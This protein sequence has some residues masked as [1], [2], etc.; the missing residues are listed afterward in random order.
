M[1]VNATAGTALFILYAAVIGALVSG[2]FVV[3]PKST[4]AASFLV[5]AATFGVLSV[6][7]FVLKKDLS[8]FGSYLIMGAIGLFIASIV[9]IFLANDALSWIITY[10]VLAVFIGLT[11]YYTQKLK[12]WALEVSDNPE[13]ASRLAVVGSLMMYVAFLNMFLSILRIMGS[14]R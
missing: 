4:L 1:S 7:G 13:M 12:G 11:V 6:L 2:I 5:T 10:G 3:Y 9:N 8:S 14:R